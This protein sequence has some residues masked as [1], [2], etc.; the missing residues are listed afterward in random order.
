MASEVTSVCDADGEILR[1][2]AMLE[3]ATLP[4]ALT[5][6]RVIANVAPPAATPS[7]TSTPESTNRFERTIPTSGLAR[8]TTPVLHTPRSDCSA[9]EAVKR[10]RWR[11]G[12]LAHPSVYNVVAG[13]LHDGYSS[14]AIVSD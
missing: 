14:G 8:L 5:P 7:C 9:N 6:R 4:E 10:T 13:E 2:S 12:G 1:S 3:M 11:T